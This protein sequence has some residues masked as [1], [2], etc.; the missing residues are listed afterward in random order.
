M[1]IRP[2]SVGILW[3]IPLLGAFFFYFLLFFGGSSVW[4]DRFETHRLYGTGG[5]YNMSASS[6]S[7]LGL[8]EAVQV[9]RINGDTLDDIVVLANGLLNNCGANGYDPGCYLGP[10]HFLY[11]SGPGKES[12]NIRA[13]VVG[14]PYGENYVGSDLAWYENNGFGNFSLHFITPKQLG[15][16]KPAVIYQGRSLEVADLGEGVQ[17]IVVCANYGTGFAADLPLGAGRVSWFENKFPATFADGGPEFIQYD[18]VKKSAGDFS[19][20]AG[21]NCLVRNPSK[22]T[23]ADMDGDS[24]KDLIVMDYAGGGISD[25]TLYWFHNNGPGV[26]KFVTTLGNVFPILLSNAGHVPYHAGGGSALTA[27][28]VNGDSR[29][30]LI[31]GQDNGTKELIYLENL[32]SGEFNQHVIKSNFLVANS[33]AVGDLYGNACQEIIT[34]GKKAI[35][36]SPPIL[37]PLTVFSA[38]NFPACDTWTETMLPGADDTGYV[39]DVRLADI[40]SDGKTD[41]IA[42]WINDSYH[43]SASL[44]SG[45]YAVTFVWINGGAANAWTSPIALE[46]AV[47]PPEE[48]TENGGGLAVADFDGDGDIDVVRAHMETDLVLFENTWNTERLIQVDTTADRFGTKQHVTSILST[49][50]NKTVGRL[51]GQKVQSK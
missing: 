33:I 8:H 44:P 9:A 46:E 11:N 16:E 51:I 22:A 41:V 26:N 50:P 48:N 21:V 39:W 49:N 27:A 31:V 36:A 25:S 4:A 47:D 45:K 18:V 23:V 14:S 3:P 7:H 1:K 32:I 29:M 12:P 40:N 24:K 28:D 6:F 37:S 2:N 13:G 15:I 17:D 43:S 34:G 38:T 30:D 35:S 20:P 19:C 10:T 42:F 5:G